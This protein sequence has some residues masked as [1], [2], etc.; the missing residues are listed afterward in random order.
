MH[1]RVVITAVSA[2]TPIGH[3]RRDIVHS[4][5]QGISGIKPLKDDEL[6]T[7]YIHSR[8]F[9]TVDYPVPY[10]F[11]RIYRKTMGPVAFYAC[12]VAKEVLEMAGL[13]NDFVVSG[14]LGV[15]F[16]STHGSPTVQRSIYKTFFGG[17]RSEY[18]A[19]GA[20]DY[21]K[22]MVHTTAVNITK[23]FGITGRVISS[24]TACTTS[25]QSIGYGYEAVK[26]GLQDAMLCGGADEY[27]TTTV[28]VF[29][30]L[31]ACSTGFN[32]TPQLTPRPFDRDRD[33]LVV[34]EG[35]GAVL[36]EEYEFARKRGAPILAEVIGFACNNNGGDLILPN[37]NGIMQT[38]RLGLA[39]ASIPADAVD[40]ISAHATATKMG[41]VI[42]AQAIGGVYGNHPHVTALK[43]YMGHTMASCGVIETIL[44]IYMMAEG[45]I[46]P[47]LNLDDVDERCAMI[48]HVRKPVEE[49]V[50]IAAIQN[51][52]FGGVNTNLLIKKFE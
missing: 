4:L 48:R 25:S 37:L 11:K 23:M 26:F 34:G 5:A 13:D 12:Q 49:K 1:R 17:D 8:V 14:R 27:D 42:E 2:I 33:G 41:D 36:L 31:L 45:W 47:T 32:D 21:L 19:I 39:D 43:S 40:L 3:D 16:G 38:I 24:S 7:R 46:A 9:G 10:D 35:A 30:N 22:S 6:L 18:T 29:D 50:R 51:F 15:A 20:V 52:A 44:L 28:A